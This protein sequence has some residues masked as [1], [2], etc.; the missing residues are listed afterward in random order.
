VLADARENGQDGAEREDAMTTAE[1]LQTV[2]LLAGALLLFI[3]LARRLPVPN[4]VLLVLGGLAL[5]LVPGAPR[6]R[7][8]PD[9]VFLVFLPPILWGAAYFTSLRDFRANAR[10]IALLAIGLVLATTAVVAVVAHAIVPGLGWAGAVALGAIVSPPDAVAATAVVR[11]LGVPRR[12]VTILEGES[13]VNDATALVLYRGAL[14]AMVAGTF[15]PLDAV[16]TFFFAATAGVVIGIGIGAIALGALQVGPDPLV[17]TA[18]TLL[19]PYVAWTLGERAHA[20]PVL[21]CVAGGLVLRQGLS[22][23]VTPSMRLQSRAVWDF[24]LFALNGMLFLLIGLQLPSLVEDVAHDQLPRMIAYGLVVSAAAIATRLA[25]VPFI[26]WLPR[27]LSPA[28]RARDPMPARSAIFLIAWTGLRGA[29]SL[30][31]ALAL[32]MATADGAPLPFRS[33][34]ILITFVVIFCTL[35]IQGASLAPLVRRLPLPAED[36][37]DR[38]ELLARTTATRAALARLDALAGEA[39][40]NATVLGEQRTFYQQRLA[41]QGSNGE[42][43]SSLLSDRAVQRTRYET[44]VAERVALV[45]L[46]DD[47]AISD[48]VLVELESELDLEAARNGLADASEAPA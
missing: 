47:G 12:V 20:S 22:L 23:R 29:V 30:A 9:L 41:R 35:V 33:E 44:L 39:W 18:V 25:W 38:E 17:Q 15:A 5:G 27:K 46:R 24:L 37:Q 4:P 10:P 7:L 45:A 3:S 6:P 36:I 28:L 42:G 31:A 1:S 26:T 32:P 16:D 11:K 34:L 19:A 8:D 43:P 48:E 2:L 40:T 14:V 21:A 13:L